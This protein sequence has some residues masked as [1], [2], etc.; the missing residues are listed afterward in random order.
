MLIMYNS[1]AATQSSLATYGTI[2]AAV[3]ILVDVISAVIVVI[4]ILQIF[5]I[6]YSQAILPFT[7]FLVAFSFALGPT[8]QRMID[9][10][11]FVAVI[12]P[13]DVNDSVSIPSI[14]SGA[15]LKVDKIFLL[16]TEFI[17]GTNRKII[18]RN[19]DLI[20]QNIVNLKQSGSVSLSCKFTVTAGCA[21]PETLAQV[22]A[23]VLQY[24]LDHGISWKPKLSLSVAASDGN[25]LDLTFSYTH[26]NS[27]SDSGKAFTDQTHL[28]LFITETLKAAG[29]EYR[30]PS[31]NVDVSLTTA[32]SSLQA[33]REQAAAAAAASTAKPQAGAAGA[34]LETLLELLNFLQ[35]RSAGGG[36]SASDAGDAERLPEQIGLRQRRTA[37][38]DTR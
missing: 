23:T 6:S 8:I 17:D 7:T 32:G 27:W 20:S 26:N 34:Q 1:W 4:V 14:N 37:G 29:L 24:L 19:S 18:A 11:L 28:V 5:N 9:S 16:T 25:R 36:G 15:T 38:A 22:K 33:A 2:S 10:L 13:M 21:T 30:N 31:S 12:A 3:R 35:A